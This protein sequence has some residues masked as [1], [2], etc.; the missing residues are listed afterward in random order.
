MMLNHSQ[1]TFA[2]KDEVEEDCGNE[3]NIVAEEYN[4]VKKEVVSEEESIDKKVSEKQKDGEE[5]FNTVTLT[6][7]VF[8][9]P[10]KPEK[11]CYGAVK[12]VKKSPGS[13]FYPS[14][15]QILQEADAK[16]LAKSTPMPRK[17][18]R[19]K[20]ETS[21]IKSREQSPSQMSA[22]TVTKLPGTQEETT[23]LFKFCLSKPCKVNIVSALQQ[24]NYASKVMDKNM[25]EKHVE[26]LNTFG[27]ESS[28]QTD[29]SSDKEVKKRGHTIQVVKFTSETKAKYRRVDAILSKQTKEIESQKLQVQFVNS[30]PVLTEYGP[31]PHPPQAEQKFNIF[32]KICYTRPNSNFTKEQQLMF[33]LAPGNVDHNSTYQNVRR[34]FTSRGVVS[35]MYLQNF[36]NSDMR[37]F[38]NVVYQNEDIVQRVLQDGCFTFFVDGGLMVPSRIGSVEITVNVFPFCFI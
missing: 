31:N 23:S 19:P 28:F 11:F 9:A 5:K 3:G 7:K 33:S 22:E 14:V 18:M 34:L 26:V 30:K 37:R 32:N 27:V 20:L 38:G 36:I 13:H 6:K 35:A 10:Y 21:V 25:D 17:L 24:E 15:E 12:K 29:V 4:V 2:D 16:L 8:T 1:D